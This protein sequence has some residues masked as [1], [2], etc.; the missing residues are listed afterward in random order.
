MPER[1]LIMG[2]A[3]PRVRPVV[4]FALCAALAGDAAAPRCA[5]GG[6]PPAPRGGHGGRADRRACAPI[7]RTSWPATTGRPTISSP[8]TR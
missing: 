8:R 2:M 6:I 1:T 5:A 7:S 3:R 4:T